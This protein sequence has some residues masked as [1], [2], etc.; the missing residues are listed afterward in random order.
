[1]PRVL[2][3]RVLDTW[4]RLAGAAAPEPE[5]ELADGAVRLTWSFEEMYLHL[6]VLAEGFLWFFEEHRAQLAGGTRAVFEPSLPAAFFENP[7]RLRV[8]T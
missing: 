8:G 4:A 3:G 1:M 7:S 6:D 2:A 5:I